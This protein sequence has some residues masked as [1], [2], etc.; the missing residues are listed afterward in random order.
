MATCELDNI[1][2]AEIVETLVT[3]ADLIEQ[4]EGHPAY[5]TDDHLNSLTSPP[6]HMIHPDRPRMAA[7]I[8]AAALVA[9]RHGEVV[10]GSDRHA[11]DRS[12]HLVGV[13]VLRAGPTCW[14][15]ASALRRAARTRGATASEAS[16]SCR[17]HPK[18]VQLPQQCRECPRLRAA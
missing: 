13:T 1:E 18:A 2:A 6:A 3:L 5:L 12:R 16:S 14:V 7:N 11:A 15:R 10:A 8:R 9:G 4:P 17:A